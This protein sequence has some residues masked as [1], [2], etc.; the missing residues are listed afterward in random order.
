MDAIEGSPGG[1]SCAQGRGLTIR[2]IELETGH[3]GLA[4]NPVPLGITERSRGGSLLRAAVWTLR[5]TSASSQLRTADGLGR[6]LV[7]RFLDWRRALDPGSGLLG[8]PG[9]QWNADDFVGDH[10]GGS[11][12]EHRLGGV[13][14]G[15]V[16]AQLGGDP[17]YEAGAR[18]D[19]EDPGR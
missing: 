6:L 9:G 2:S 11:V 10:G 4:A 7:R 8:S 17:S 16:V 1:R 18:S 5:V 15:H 14:G 19:I 12:V 13:D 3:S